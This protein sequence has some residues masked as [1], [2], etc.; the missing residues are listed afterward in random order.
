MES[1]QILF[2]YY[3]LISRIQYEINKKKKNYINKKL[4]ATYDK[5]CLG[6]QAANFA[7]LITVTLK[8]NFK[9]FLKINIFI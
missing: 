2:K 6:L 1:V 4:Y 5:L 3:T 7:K 9:L 8:L